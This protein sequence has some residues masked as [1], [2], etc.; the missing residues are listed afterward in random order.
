M[1]SLHARFDQRVEVHVEVEPAAEALDDRER[2]GAASADAT[3]VGLARVESEQRPR[4]YRQHGPGETVIPRPQV[5]QPVREREDPLSHRDGRQDVVHQVRGALG[6]PPAPAA[7]AE[8]ATLTREED[9]ALE[10]AVPAAHPRE[11]VGQHP[12]GQE[13][14]ELPRDELGQ[15]GAI[16]TIRRGAQKLVQVLTDDGVEHARLG[17]AGSV[18]CM[19][20]GH[21]PR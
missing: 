19:I 9:Q 11:A 18:H 7:R 20:A 6:H 10:R 13:L 16:G 15:P 4:V 5:P 1:P 12:A 17:M 2:A 14:A 8:A 21:R 3:A